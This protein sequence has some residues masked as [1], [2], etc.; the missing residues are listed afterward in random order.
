MQTADPRISLARN[1]SIIAIVKFEISH[2][3][4]NPLKHADRNR[5]DAR[6]CSRV[7]FSSSID[8]LEEK[9]CLLFTHEAFKKKIDDYI[10][11]RR[12]H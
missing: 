6:A 1:T 2:N 7:L 12:S 11:D 3:M 4:R 5:G 9:R 10:E 8:P